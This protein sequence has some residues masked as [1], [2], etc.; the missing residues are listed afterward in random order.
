[1]KMVSSRLTL[2]MKFVFPFVFIFGFGAGTLSIWLDQT[3]DENGDILPLEEK[4]KF[5]AGWIFG[6]TYLLWSGVGLK[7]VRMDSTHLYV[8][9]FR[10]EIALP[11]KDVVDITEHHWLNWSS[12]IHFRAPTEFGQS[13]KF[14]HPDSF[15]PFYYF[16]G[17]H[18]AVE[19][20][21]ER[22]GLKDG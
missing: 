1:M 17:S 12:T 16:W 3:H 5:L 7:K 18:S 15:I 22:V 9:N 8:S 2:L 11:F 4:W 6:T 19:D 10:K 13:I 20:L 14:L 21:K